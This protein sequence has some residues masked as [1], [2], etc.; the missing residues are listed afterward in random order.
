MEFGRKFPLFNAE[1]RFRTDRDS[2][3]YGLTKT[4]DI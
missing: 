1:L 4:K 2:Q 3:A